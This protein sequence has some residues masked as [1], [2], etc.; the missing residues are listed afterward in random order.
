M[1]KTE[2]YTS[3]TGAD[4]SI[5]TTKIIGIHGQATVPCSV[6]VEATGLNLKAA[7][8]DI[9]GV[10]GMAKLEASASATGTKISVATTGIKGVQGQAN[11]S[12]NAEATGLLILVEPK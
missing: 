2:S 10:K 3:P 11:A 1:N 12:L 5:A 8:A 7:H 6:N 4:I 9:T